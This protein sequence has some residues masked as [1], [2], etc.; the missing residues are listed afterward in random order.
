MI[1]SSYRQSDYLQPNE[2]QVFKYFRTIVMRII[3][4][5]KRVGVSNAVDRLVKKLICGCI[6]LCSDVIEKGKNAPVHA[7]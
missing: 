5:I 3:R 4:Q 6:G 2:L 1:T 7:F